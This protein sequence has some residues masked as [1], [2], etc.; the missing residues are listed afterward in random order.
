MQIWQVTHKYKKKFKKIIKNLLSLQHS[1]NRERSH[2]FFPPAQQG[3]THV[4]FLFFLRTQ[5]LFFLLFSFFLRDQV[6]K[7]SFFFFSFNKK[8]TLCL[9]FF[10]ETMSLIIFF[11]LLFFFAGRL[12]SIE[13]VMASEICVV[14][15]VVE[16]RKISYFGL[17]RKFTSTFN[18]T[19]SGW[20]ILFSPDLH[21]RLAKRVS[22][23]TQSLR[24]E[25]A[26]RRDVPLAVPT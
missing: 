13:Q 26:T 5:V 9:F 25:T 3:F 20:L 16:K 2:Y 24:R 21:F 15:G 7:M 19:Q 4:S 18:F 8:A 12:L 14:V 10:C 6:P 22:G 17:A 1:Q 11:F 23:Q